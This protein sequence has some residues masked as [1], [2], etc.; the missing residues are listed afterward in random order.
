MAGKWI[1]CPQNCPAPPPHP[2]TIRAIFT[3]RR[4]SWRPAFHGAHCADRHDLPHRVSDPRREGTLHADASPRFEFAAC[5]GISS[6]WCG[7]FLFACIYVWGPWPAG[8][9]RAWRFSAAHFAIPKKGG[10]AAALLFCTAPDP[11][12]FLHDP[13]FAATSRFRRQYFAKWSFDS[14]HSQKCLPNR[15]RMLESGHQG[16]MT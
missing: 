1:Q 7:C 3:A 4:S 9:R 11:R 10:H 8:P 5:T 2:S 13:Q 14:K 15:V 12:C 6:T 16:E